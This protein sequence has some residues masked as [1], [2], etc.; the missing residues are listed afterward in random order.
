MQG[1]G[2]DELLDQPLAP[3]L[4]ETGQTLKEQIFRD[5][6]DIIFQDMQVGGRVAGLLVYT[7]GLAETDLMADNVVRPLLF[8]LAEAPVSDLSPDRLARAGLG[9]G[10]VATGRHFKDVVTAV[11]DGKAA[12]LVD[13]YAQCLTFGV[14]GGQRRNIEEP[15][16]EVVVRGPREGFNEDLSTSVSL[17]RARIRTP[18]LKTVQWRIGAQTRTRV[19]LLYLEGVANPDVISEVKRRLEDIKIDGVLESGYIESFLEDQPFSP[20][21]QMLYSERPDTVAAMLLEGRIAIVTDGTPFVLVA[22]VTFW[23]FFKTSEDYY[24]RFLIGSFLRTLRM[25]FGLVALFLPALYVAVITFHQDMLPTSLMLSIASAREAIPFPALVEA[26]MMELSFEGL[27]EAGVRLPKT[28]GQA[29]SILG[30]LVIGQAAVEA[31][32]VS[33]PMVI[34]V[35]LTGIA[36]FTIPHFNGAISLRL[37]RFP[38]MLLAGM[39]GMVGISLGALWIGIHLCSLRSFGMPYLTGVAPFDA[40][41]AKDL[42]VRAPWWAMIRRP[43]GLKR[44]NRRRMPPG[45]KPEAPSPRR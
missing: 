4:A 8:D 15:P 20:F 25:A 24:E 16:S 3:V 19:V 2:L 5:C 23:Q 9:P 18:R 13:G 33:A 22:P 38:M 1:T 45:Q 42:M 7:V 14:K 32:I 44:V 26:A 6:A 28:V 37:L 35:S 34:I 17:L 30:A 21:P 11:L 29:V 31:G 43:S 10:S 40:S 39:F 27:R 41:D 36:S 12:L